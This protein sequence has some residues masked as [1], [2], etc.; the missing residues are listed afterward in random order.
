MWIVCLYVL[1]LLQIGNLSCYTAFLNMTTGSSSL[2]LNLHPEWDKWKKMDWC[3][4]A[5]SNSAL[6]LAL[7]LVHFKSIGGEKNRF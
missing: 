1:V 5:K 4:N 3:M 6:P 7:S 2:T